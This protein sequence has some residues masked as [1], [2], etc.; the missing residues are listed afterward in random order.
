MM[1]VPV[2]Q[3]RSSSCMVFNLYMVSVIWAGA[4]DALRAYLNFRMLQNV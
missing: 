3:Q 1:Q 2:P 4:L